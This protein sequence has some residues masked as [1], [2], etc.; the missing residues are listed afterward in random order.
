MYVLV[1]AT[2]FT[3]RVGHRRQMNNREIIITMLPIQLVESTLGS[4]HTRSYIT[5]DNRYVSVGIYVV[6][7]SDGRVSQNGKEQKCVAEEQ[8]ERFPTDDDIPIEAEPD[9]FNLLRDTL[10]ILSSLTSRP[11]KI[12]S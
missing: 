7:G 8:S 5:Y 10:I 4:L 9:T 2:A 1:L 3:R 6:D 11:Q 12:Q